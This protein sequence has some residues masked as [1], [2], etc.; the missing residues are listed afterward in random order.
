MYSTRRCWVDRLRLPPRTGRDSTRFRKTS[1]GS[2]LCTYAHRTGP[3]RHPQ[4]HRGYLIHMRSTSPPSGTA[5]LCGTAPIIRTNYNRSVRGYSSQSYLGNQVQTYQPSISPLKL[6]GEVPR[7]RH[8][9][10]P[11]ASQ[12]TIWVVKIPSPARIVRGLRVDLPIPCVVVRRGLTMGSP[13]IVTTLLCGPWTVAT[14][15]ARP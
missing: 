7:L 12:S 3:P 10:T 11:L 5:L 8:Q 6:G 14:G 15:D 2:G 13:A 1:R 4:S 9:A